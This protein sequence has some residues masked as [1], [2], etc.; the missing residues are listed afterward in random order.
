[1]IHTTSLCTFA[2]YFALVVLYL[3]QM[4]NQ[5]KLTRVAPVRKV[6][7]YGAVCFHS[8]LMGSVLRRYGF[9]IFESGADLFLWVSWIVSLL[10]TFSKRLA[11]APIVALVVIP[12]VIAFLGSSSYVMHGDTP[13]VQLGISERG[14]VSLS[15]S[16]PVLVVLTSFVLLFIGSVVFLVV[17]RRL[18]AK[19]RLYLGDSGVSLEYLDRANKYLAH[20][21][22]VGLSLVIASGGMRAVTQHK[23]LSFMDPSVLTGCVVWVLLGVL[24]HFRLVRQW[25]PRRL[26]QCT[27]VVAGGFIVS[28]FLILLITGRITHGAM[29][30]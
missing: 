16:V 6:L 8:V 29:Y 1:M 15:H 28:V 24:L 23:P 21:G 9:T 13:G 12:L 5:V 19:D 14:L 27:V 26:A 17:E 25:S 4:S 18:R 10:F 2:L 7:L 20:I 22:F 11:S 30:A 3:L